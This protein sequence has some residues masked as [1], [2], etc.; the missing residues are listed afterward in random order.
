MAETDSKRYHLAVSYLLT[1]SQLAQAGDHSSELFHGLTAVVQG[2]IMRTTPAARVRLQKLWRVMCDVVNKDNTETL[3]ESRRA[4]R[5]EAARWEANGRPD[6][7][8]E[9]FSL[10]DDTGE[11]YGSADSTP[12]VGRD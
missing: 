12:F 3:P 8:R 11:S 6:V 7:A 2:Y 5:A 9:L 1:L 10:A 4:A